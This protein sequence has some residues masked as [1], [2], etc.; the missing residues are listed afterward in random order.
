MSRPHPNPPPDAL[1]ALAERWR[2]TDRVAVLTGAGLST[3]SGIPDFRSPGGRW[4]QYQPV[5]IQEFLAS[6]GARRRYWAYKGETWRVITAAR[7]NP[8][9]AA[10]ADLAR[11]GRIELLVTQ[12]V[13]GLHERSAVPPDRLVNVHGTDS[14]IGCVDCDATAPR[15]VA[16]DAWEA[17]ALV[18]RCACGGAWKPATISF[19]QALVERDLTRAFDAAAGC[20]LFVAAGTSLVVGPINQMFTLAAQAGAATAIV[21]ASETPFDD[22]AT[23]RLHEPVEVVLPVVRDLV[24]GRG[25]T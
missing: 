7:P 3:A 18:P 22:A 4:S 6:E 15:A 20:D 19:G 5:T 9:H 16:Q 10:L 13:D 1:Q 2:R 17:G 23:W 12:N 11:A 14:A 25:A 8:G 21:A 24:L